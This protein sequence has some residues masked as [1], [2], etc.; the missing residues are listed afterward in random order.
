MTGVGPEKGNGVGFQMEGSV[1]KS[2]FFLRSKGNSTLSLPRPQVQSLIGELRSSK[3]CSMA[4]KRKRKS[5]KI[6]LL[7]F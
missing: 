3:P 1:L 7:V 6:A 5:L 4:K 2:E